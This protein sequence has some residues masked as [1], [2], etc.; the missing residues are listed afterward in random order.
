MKITAEDLQYFDF[1]QT[2][3]TTI[4]EGK[5]NERVIITLTRKLLNLIELEA[6]EVDG[7]VTKLVVK[8]TSVVIGDKPLATH[9]LDNYVDFV[10]LMD[11]ILKAF[12]KEES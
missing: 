3:K 7:E 5:E 11:H 12:K 4:D 9:K 2:R 10:L 1:K 8:L 6:E